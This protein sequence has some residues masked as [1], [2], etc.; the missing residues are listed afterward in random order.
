M[1]VKADKLNNNA[2]HIRG[3]VKDYAAVLIT[4]AFLELK[5]F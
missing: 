3:D 4:N 1:I 2:Q 5:E